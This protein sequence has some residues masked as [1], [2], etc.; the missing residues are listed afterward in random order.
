MNLSSA[1]V[2][3]LSQAFAISFNNNLPQPTQWEFISSSPVRL[4]EFDWQVA[5]ALGDE[6]SRFLPPGALLSVTLLVGER[7]Q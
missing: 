7:R 1:S 3:Q 6:G 4:I 2:I 5:S